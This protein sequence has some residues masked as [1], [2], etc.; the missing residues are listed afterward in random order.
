MGTQSS[1]RTEAKTQRWARGEW[2]S[3]DTE[4]EE[5]AK[6]ELHDTCSLAL[7]VKPLAQKPKCQHD[8]GPMWV[9]QSQWPVCGRGEGPC[10]GACN[11]H[12]PALAWVGPLAWASF[13]QAI[14]PHGGTGQGK[15]CAKVA[16]TLP[17]E[18]WRQ[19]LGLAWLP[20][21][22]AGLF[23]ELSSLNISPS[24]LVHGPVAA[25]SKYSLK[26]TVI[27][28]IQ[29]HFWEGFP[30]SPGLNS[31]LAQGLVCTSSTV[32]VLGNHRQ[33]LSARLPHQTVSSQCG[34]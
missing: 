5:R 7:E 23:W 8:S 17:G 6:P 19:V 26:E 18:A 30:D 9:A 25:D 32:F 21:L 15:D 3:G 33:S 12:L 14:L 34:G 4:A 13:L 22:G 16:G 27:P 24:S 31:R 10:P 11:D 29:C 28:E 1:R 2:K 20:A